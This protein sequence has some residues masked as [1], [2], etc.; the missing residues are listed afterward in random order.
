MN[1]FREGNLQLGVLMIGI[2]CVSAILVLSTNILFARLLGPHQ[3]GYY[4]YTLSIISL[5][6]VVSSMGL[7]NLLIR[8]ISK[9][10]TLKSWGH[11]KGIL[12]YSSRVL[13][14]SILVGI[15]IAI[16]FSTNAKEKV[17]SFDRNTF[18]VSVLL[19]PFM[20]IGMIRTAILRGF[21]R[22]IIS[23]LPDSIIKNSIILGALLFTVFLN[24]KLNSISAVLITLLSV[25]I[26]FIIGHYLL[27]TTLS[28]EITSATHITYSNVWMR[29]MATFLVVDIMSIA[30]SNI[31][32][33][34]LGFFNGPSSVGIYQVASRGAEFIAF[35]LMA[36]NMLFATKIS[37][38]YVKNKLNELQELIK[39][40]TIIIILISAPVLVLIILL[41]QV[42]VSTLFGNSYTSGY[43][44]LVILSVG[45]FI[46][47]LMG[48]A[49]LLLNMTGYERYTAFGISISVSIS[50]IFN[51]LLIPQYGVVGAAVSN[52]MGL[53]VCSVAYVYWVKKRTGINTLIFSKFHKK[54]N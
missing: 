19:L 7:P 43:S 22:I 34:L 42:L 48:S 20:T 23:Q 2:K 18:L 3:L 44:V 16:F 41:G 31:D 28:K 12:K 10:E 17:Q 35:P 36:I 15:I 24:L 8:E 33:L 45:Q 4:T 13:F 25:V 49:A 14:F 47:V 5:I 39:R 11:I 54:G 9:Y 26:V 21:N 50:T 6:S 1:V 46:K 32:V 52:C 30:S 29:S 53:I 40:S 38:L 51:L 27:I 37:Q